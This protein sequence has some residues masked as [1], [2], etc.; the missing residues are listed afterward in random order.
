MQGHGRTEDVPLD[1]TSE[2]LGDDA[3]G[4]IYAGDNNANA[5]FVFSASANGIVAPVRTITGLLTTIN[6]PEKVTVF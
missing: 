1:C 5:I 4:N 6:S 2:N 3:A